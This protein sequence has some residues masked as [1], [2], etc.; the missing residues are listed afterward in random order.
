MTVQLA[1]SGGIFSGADVTYR[2]VSVGRAAR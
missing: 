1:E 2:G